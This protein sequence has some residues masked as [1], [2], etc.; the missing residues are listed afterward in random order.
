MA[1]EAELE[2]ESQAVERRIW[3]ENYEK[4]SVES[5]NLQIDEVTSRAGELVAK[6]E[7]SP[8]IFIKLGQACRLLSSHARYVA[9]PRFS[10]FFK[11]K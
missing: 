7:Y 6:K 4:G 2:L 3:A 8:D 5:L 1:P 9:G 10:D 11:E